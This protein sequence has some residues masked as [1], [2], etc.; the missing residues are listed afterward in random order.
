[1]WGSTPFSSS[2]TSSPR[3]SRRIANRSPVCRFSIINS[4]TP[5]LAIRLSG[6]DAR[7]GSSPGHP[8]SPSHIISPWPEV[9]LTSAELAND[10]ARRF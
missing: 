10:Q 1:M 9:T 4:R 2:H 3:F 7:P 8:D 5:L 6:F